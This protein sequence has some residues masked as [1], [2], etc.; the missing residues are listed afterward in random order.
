MST[1]LPLG[2]P[3]L[4]DAVRA[5]YK[6]TPYELTWSVGVTQPASAAAPMW[7]IW[8]GKTQFVSDSPD[9]VLST[10]RLAFSLEPL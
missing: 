3:E 9:N 4:V 7:T 2:F 6:G 10:A 8:A 1:P 5:L